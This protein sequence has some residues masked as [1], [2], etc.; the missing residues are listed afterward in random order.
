MVVTESEKKGLDTNC[1]ETEYM[2]VSRRESKTC[3][4]EEILFFEL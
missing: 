1:K 4:L 3:K 2:V